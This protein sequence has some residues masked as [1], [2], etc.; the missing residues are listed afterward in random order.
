[1]EICEKLRRPGRAVIQRNTLLGEV[2]LISGANATLEIRACSACAG[3]YEDPDRT[4][5]A[6]DDEE[7]DEGA[8]APRATTEEF[9]AEDR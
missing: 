2:Y 5:W 1:M 3:D 4:A 6:P 7:E 9:P 8:G